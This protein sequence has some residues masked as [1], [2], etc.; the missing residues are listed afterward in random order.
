MANELNRDPIWWGIAHGEESNGM[1]AWLTRREEA[2]WRDE[3]R[4]RDGKG[5]AALSEGD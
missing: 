3:R 2:L 5:F 4:V 1:T